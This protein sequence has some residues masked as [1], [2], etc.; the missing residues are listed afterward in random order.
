MNQSEYYFLLVELRVMD[1]LGQIGLVVVGENFGN[2]FYFLKDFK[3]VL[4]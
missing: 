4:E 3:F 2:I 1:N